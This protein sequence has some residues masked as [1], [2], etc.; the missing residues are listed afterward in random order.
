MVTKE[1]KFDI[2]DKVTIPGGIEA[3]VIGL[4][5]SKGMSV[6]RIN[7]QYVNQNKSVIMDWLDEDE[8]TA[9]EVA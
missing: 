9:L 8:L 6:N 3:T 1:F 5:I 2:G 7:V 4:S